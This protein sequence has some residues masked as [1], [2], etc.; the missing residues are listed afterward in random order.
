MRQKLRELGE[1][2]LR[3]LDSC[4]RASV[5]HPFLGTGGTWRWLGSVLE[6]DS[7]LGRVQKPGPDWGQIFHFY[8]KEMPPHTPD[9]DLLHLNGVA[10]FR[11]NTR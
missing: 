3:R 7:S 8:E 2:R 5:L 11:L 1:M 6:V 9:W 4:P 10:P